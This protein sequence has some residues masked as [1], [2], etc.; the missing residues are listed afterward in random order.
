MFLMAPVLFTSKIATD[1]LS[2]QML[3]ISDDVFVDTL[4]FAFI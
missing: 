4:Q 1:K 2:Q 3:I